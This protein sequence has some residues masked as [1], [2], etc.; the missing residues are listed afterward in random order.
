MKSTSKIAFIIILFI[1]SNCGKTDVEFNKLQWNEKNDVFYINR[2]NMVNDLLKNHLKKGMTYKEL[3]SL[4]GYPQNYET[5][6][7]NTIVYEIMEN[8]GWDIDPI[9]TKILMIKLSKDSLVETY[10]IKHWKK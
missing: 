4:I 8:Y 9:E 7:S 3:R 5:Q 2:E 10:E 6:N 1:L